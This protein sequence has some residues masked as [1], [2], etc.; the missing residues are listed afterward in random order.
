MYQER[1]SRVVHELAP[2]IAEAM[3]A[4]VLEV[5]ETEGYG[6]WDGFWWQ[7]RGLPKPGEVFS[8]PI[9][10]GQG[11][12]QK[13]Q[14]RRG[15]LAK[16]NR[17]WQGQPKLLQDTGNLVGSLTPNWDENAVEVYTN[18]PYAV[19]HVSPAP[20]RKIPLRDFFAID[21]EAF[22]Q[23]VVDMIDMHFRRTLPSAAE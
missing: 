14:L 19:F 11:K 3:H 7:R 21:A 10:R 2:A 18:V 12:R 20:R 1:G 23:D 6:Q 9:Q 15:K 5:F 13:K 17:R 8:G 16:S 4:E 22:E